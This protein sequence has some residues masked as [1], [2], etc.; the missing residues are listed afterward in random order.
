MVLSFFWFSEGHRKLVV[1]PFKQ[2]TFAFLNT[3]FEP[4]C[5]E[6]QGTQVTTFP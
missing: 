4:F 2:N 3:H 5:R 6:F 1:G